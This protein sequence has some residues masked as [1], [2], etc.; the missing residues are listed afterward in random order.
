MSEIGK[1]HIQQE[2]KHIE[3]ICKKIPEEPSNHPT[4]QKPSADCHTSKPIHLVP[5]QKRLGAIS[6]NGG[7]PTEMSIPVM[8]QDFPLIDSSISQS[9]EAFSRRRSDRKAKVSRKTKTS[10]I[11]RFPERALVIPTDVASDDGTN[12]QGERPQPSVTPGLGDHWA[13][14]EACKDL[15]IH[16]L[17]KPVLC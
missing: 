4:Q 3:T 14:H 11:W 8:L 16:N 5:P 2:L 9:Q 6:I 15:E 12:M 13:N 10:S 7:P 17:Y 1:W